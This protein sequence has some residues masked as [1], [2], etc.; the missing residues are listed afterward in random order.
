[1]AGMVGVLRLCGADVG[2]IRKRA[3]ATRHGDQVG[4]TA[5]QIIVGSK[6][7]LQAYLEA[8]EAPDEHHSSRKKTETPRPTGADSHVSIWELRLTGTSFRPRRSLWSCFFAGGD[9]LQCALE[10]IRNSPKYGGTRR[11]SGHFPLH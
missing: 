1:M 2:G 6:A 7:P 3:T 5:R 11:D 10:L 9:F 8:I 4:P